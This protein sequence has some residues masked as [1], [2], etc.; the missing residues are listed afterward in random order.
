M[1]AKSPLDSFS[2]AVRSLVED[3]SN[4]PFSVMVSAAFLTSGPD[5][6]PPEEAQRLA[7]LIYAAD[8]GDAGLA[9][10]LLE[11]GADPNAIYAGETLLTVAARNGRLGVARELIR[12]GADVVVPEYRGHEALL[13]WLFHE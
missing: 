4:I 12:A 7:L 10:R 13:K 5:A 8:Y 2:P 9:R 11:A 3:E 6:L 1:A